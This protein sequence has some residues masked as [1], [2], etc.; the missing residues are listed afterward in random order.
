MQTLRL[1]IQLAEALT[2]ALAGA[3]KVGHPT[4]ARLAVRS[5]GVPAPLA[6]ALA[7]ALPAAE[8]AVAGLLVLGPLRGAALAAVTLTVVFNLAVGLR[9]LRGDL[10]RCHCFGRW[11]GTIGWTTI[12][13]NAALSAGALFL[14]WSAVR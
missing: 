6:P 9:A 2:F 7:L 14:V 10:G 5:A 12:G 3:L 4:T 8:L 1:S 11:S 13:R